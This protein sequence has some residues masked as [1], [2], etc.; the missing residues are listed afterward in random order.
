MA[1]VEMRQGAKFYSKIG[2]DEALPPE[3]GNLIG[4]SLGPDRTTPQGD[5]P[6][7]GWQ[8]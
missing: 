5:M 8:L 2:P 6:R 7:L 1:A 4:R 3:E